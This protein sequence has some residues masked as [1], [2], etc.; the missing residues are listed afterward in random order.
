MIDAEPPFV[1][2]QIDLKIFEEICP[3]IDTD[4]VVITQKQM[5]HIAHRHAE[6]Y[7]IVLENMKRVLERPFALFK[8][9]RNNNTGIVVGEVEKTKI[10]LIVRMHT[11]S[12]KPGHSNSIITGWK[13]TNKSYKRIEKKNQLLYK[14]K[15]SYYNGDEP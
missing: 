4:Y 15:P 5:K 1:V 10:V 9:S 8:D 12:D 3:N 7:S 6:A 14:R 13:V 2:A 11:S